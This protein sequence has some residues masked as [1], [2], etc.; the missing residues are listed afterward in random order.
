MKTII[1]LTIMAVVISVPV[2]YAMFY[3]TQERAERGNAKDQFDFGVLHQK[4]TSTAKYAFVQRVNGWYQNVPEPSDAKAVEW[5]QKAAEQG[6]P[7]AQFFLGIMYGNGSGVAQSDD[8]AFEWI[9]KAAAQGYKDAKQ[10]LTQ[11]SSNAQTEWNFNNLTT[12]LIQEAKKRFSNR[13]HLRAVVAAVG[14]YA[15]FLYRRAE[16][17]LPPNWQCG[18]SEK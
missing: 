13:I 2:R 16:K 3:G 18:A 17:I 14:L 6:L 10:L 1:L 5:Y 8:K 12:S 4:A 9:Q 7:E 15:Y 11:K